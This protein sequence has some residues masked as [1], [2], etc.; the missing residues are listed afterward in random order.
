[1]FGNSW[2]VVD[3]P[4][5]ITSPRGIQLQLGGNESRYSFRK[6]DFV[7]I[8][9][10]DVC[11]KISE[12]TPIGYST[13]WQQDSSDVSAN[14][15]LPNFNGYITY[16]F[17]TLSGRKSKNVKNY[18][19]EFTPAHYIGSLKD[20]SLYDDL[21]ANRTSIIGFTQLRDFFVT[22][23][24]IQ[25]TEF[26]SVPKLIQFN[27]ADT[28]VLNFGRTCRLANHNS[29]YSA[30]Y[31][32]SS[33]IYTSV[34]STTFDTAIL[35]PIPSSPVTP[36]TGIQSLL[37]HYSVGYFGENNTIPANFT[38]AQIDN[39]VTDYLKKYGSSEVGY[40]EALQRVRNATPSFLGSFNN[41]S[42]SATTLADNI[43]YKF[44]SLMEFTVELDNYTCG[45][46]NLF[47]ECVT[48]A[49]RQ[50]PTA[51]IDDAI[52]NYKLRLVKLSLGLGVVTEL[53]IDYENRKIEA[54]GY[55][56]PFVQNGIDYSV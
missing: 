22:G 25:G 50:T 41:T 49:I 7:N 14:K 24:L 18:N 35:Q 1:L 8:E 52:I 20:D 11:Y 40:T 21:R 34:V 16:F 26:T 32:M 31:R 27:V 9:T 10:M 28:N 3:V 37:P 23:T 2:N 53:E 19:V 46:D 48:S 38:D 44:A 33:V 29:S 17:N 56:I 4:I 6:E 47:E 12:G 5:S 55:V 54:S 43:G 30:A 36:V 15:Q 45:Q 51:G 42:S 39:L 13:T